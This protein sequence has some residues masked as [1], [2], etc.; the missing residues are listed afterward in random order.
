LC[1]FREKVTL[2]NPQIFQ[3]YNYKN[4]LSA[5]YAQSERGAHSKSSHAGGV[6]GGIQIKIPSQWSISCWM[7]CAVQ[8][9]K[10]L[11]RGLPSMVWYCTLMLW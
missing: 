10:V 7:I 11:M 5:I 2:E 8:P 6:Y 9:V 3:S 4:I 1:P